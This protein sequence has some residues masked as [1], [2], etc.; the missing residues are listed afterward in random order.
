MKEKFHCISPPLDTLRTITQKENM[1]TRQMSPFFSFTFSDLT[2]RNIHF[3]NWK[4]SKFIFMCSPL[5]PIL[6]CKIPHFLAKSYQFRQLIT[7][8]KY[9]LVFKMSWRRLH[10]VFSVTILRLPRRLE[11][12]LQD[13]LKMSWRRLGRRKIVTLKTSWRRLEDMSWRRLG[14]KQNNYWEYLYLTNLNLYLI[15]L[16]FIYLYLTNQGESLKMH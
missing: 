6:V 16:Y 12:I 3:W 2:V 14:D 15:N 1:E 7:H 8:S 9:L 4:Y 13:V 11:D 10:H 5:W